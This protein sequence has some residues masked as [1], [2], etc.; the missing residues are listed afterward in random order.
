MRTASSPPSRIIVEACQ[1]F[2]SFD[3]GMRQVVVAQARFNGLTSRVCNV[4]LM[5]E[6]G[7]CISPSLSLVEG[8]VRASQLHIDVLEMKRT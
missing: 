4:C 7:T 5:S 3:R 8:F 2:M 6:N 1:V